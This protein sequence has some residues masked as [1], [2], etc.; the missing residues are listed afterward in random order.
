MYL[1]PYY[2]YIYILHVKRYSGL[3]LKY[4]EETSRSSERP[5]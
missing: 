4:S 5:N 1:L 2:K 3:L